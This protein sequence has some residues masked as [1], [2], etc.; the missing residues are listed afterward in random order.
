MQCI[1]IARN[2]HAS[3]GQRQMSSQKAE[4][5]T[6]VR[7]P[8]LLPMS[9]EVFGTSPLFPGNQQE[10]DQRR[11]HEERRQQSASLRKEMLRDEQEDMLKN[12]QTSGISI[13]KNA[14]FRTFGSFLQDKWRFLS[15]SLCSLSFCQFARFYQTISA[16]LS[17]LFVQIVFS[18]SDS[19]GRSGASPA[20]ERR[21]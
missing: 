15:F 20:T 7:K 6:S 12:K 3:C 17:F 5:D 14:L 1:S 10:V 9:I 16:F 4:D 18:V 11:P 13:R 21:E 2:D 19:S 8:S